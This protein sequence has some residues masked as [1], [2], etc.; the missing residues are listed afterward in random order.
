M[1]IVG[2]AEAPVA[3]LTR[4]A[5]ARELARR[6]GWVV[7]NDVVA[8]AGGGKVAVDRARRDQAF[9]LGLLL[10]ALEARRKLLAQQVIPLLAFGVGAAPRK[11]ARLE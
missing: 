7:E 6:V 4:E 8:V 9:A 3:D 11:P 5:K 2:E 1:Q 10:I